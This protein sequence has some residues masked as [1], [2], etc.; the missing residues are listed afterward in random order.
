M[1]AI[2]LSPVI[3][4]KSMS[5]A[6]RG[7]FTFRVAKNVDKKSITRII[8]EKFKVEVV[9]I[10]TSIVK[11]KKRRF[12][13]RRTEVALPIW[14]KVVVKLKKGQKI[15]MFEAAIPQETVNLPEEK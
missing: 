13:N 10:S 15:P 11:G 3:S 5:D 9:S 14:K 1:H 8:T 7:K 12:G 2:N 4:E 6:G